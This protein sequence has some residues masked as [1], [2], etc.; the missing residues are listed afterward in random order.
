ML[1]A[2]PNERRITEDFLLTFVVFVQLQLRYSFESKS[3]FF[4]PRLRQDVFFLLM[5]ISV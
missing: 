3:F 5:Q 1:I 2:F 4:P